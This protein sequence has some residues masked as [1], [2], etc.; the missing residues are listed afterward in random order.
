MLQPVRKLPAG[1]STSTALHN[2][3]LI[4]QGCTGLMMI[5]E[6]GE[7]A[8][9]KKMKKHLTAVLLGIAMCFELFGTH[10]MSVDVRA[11][12][13]QSNSGPV[14]LSDP[15]IA[16][17]S[18]M[19]SG[20]KVTWDCVWFG[21]YPQKKVIPSPEKYTDILGESYTIEDKNLYEALQSATGWDDHNDITLNGQKYRRIR[22]EDA[23]SIY[24][25]SD[26]YGYIW[27]DDNSWSDGWHYFKYEPIK[28]RIL[29]K[30]G[31]Q[32]LLL[33]DVVLD[34]QRFHAEEAE[35]TWETSTVRSWLN[36]YRAD[37]NQQ[38]TSYENK[39]F[40]HS[41]FDSREQAAIA[42]TSVQNESNIASGTDAGNH[43]RD[44]IFFL[45]E[46]ESYGDSAM[47]YGFASEAAVDDEARRC[48]S[49]AFAKAMGAHCEEELYSGN[50]LWWLRSPGENQMSAGN[51]T[52]GGTVYDTG[53]DVSWDLGV[54][55][56]L[57]LELSSDQWSYAG[58]VCSDG[59]VNE[60]SPSDPDFPPKP[61]NP[62]SNPVLVR[63]TYEEQAATRV[64]WDCIYFGSYPQTEVLS[65]ELR[66]NYTAFEF[67]REDDFIE[68]DRLYQKLQQAYGWD[69]RNDI[70]IDGKK[71]RRMKQEDALWYSGKDGDK[72]STLVG[73][74]GWYE[75][76]DSTSWH[77][78]RYDPIKWRVLECEGNQAF[79]VADRVLDVRQW[80]LWR[81]QYVNNSPWADCALRGWLNGYVS[82]REGETFNYQQEN[83]IDCAFTEEEQNLILSSDL[84]NPENDNIA[85]DKI[86]IL[87]KDE[88]ETEAYGFV[89]D[90]FQ[91]Q[92]C[93][94]ESSSYAKAMGV[95]FTNRGHANPVDVNGNSVWWLRSTTFDSSGLYGTFG[96]EK[97]D[98][99]TQKKRYGVRPALRMD[100]S[101]PSA[102]TRAG[103]VSFDKT[104]TD[105]AASEGGVPGLSSPRIEEDASLNAGR[106]V[107]WDCVYFGSYPQAEVVTSAMSKD[108]AALK[109]L[110]AGKEDLYISDSVYHTLESTPDSSWNDH[111]EITL[112]DGKKYRRM[113][114]EDA[115]ESIGF[116]SSGCYNWADD[117][118]HY[119]QYEPVKW[120]VLKTDG[121]KAYLV[122]DR[123][124][125]YQVYNSRHAPYYISK[126]RSWLNGYGA[127]KNDGSEDFRTDR[128]FIDSAFSEAEQDA[129]L[130]LANKSWKY[131]SYTLSS[132]TK[133]ERKS[134]GTTVVDKIN[135]LS[136]WDL[137][138]TDEAES[139]G[140][141]RDRSLKDE[142]RRCGGSLYAKA[143]GLNRMNE[144]YLYTANAGSPDSVL[145]TGCFS[146]EL[147]AGWNGVRPAIWLD[148]S[149]ADCYTSAGTV[150]TREKPQMSG[151]C[152]KNVKWNFHEETGELVISGTGP[153][154]DY[155]SITDLPWYELRKERMVTRITVE[156]GVTRI[157]KQAFRSMANILGPHWEDSLEE[158]EI[159]DSVKEIG[160]YAFFNCNVLKSAAIPDG[161]EK[162]GTGA[163]CYCEQMKKLT[164]GNRVKTVGS[165]AFA[166]SGI[167]ELILPESVASLGEDEL[168][169]ET[170]D[171]DT[172]FSSLM[173]KGGVC[174]SCPNL[175]RV[176]LPSGMTEIPEQMFANCTSLTEIQ[177]PDGVTSIGRFAFSQ[178]SAL[179]EIVIPKSVRSIGCYTFAGCSALKRVEFLGRAPVFEKEG[180]GCLA[181]KDVEADVYYP[182]DDSTW[183]GDVR[184]SYGGLLGWIPKSQEPVQKAEQDFKVNPAK[185]ELTAGEQAR[186]T[187]TGAHG[188]IS[189]TGNK[190]SVI[191]VRRDGMVTALS[192]GEAEITA[193]ASGDD[194]YLPAEKKIAVTV[195]R[196]A[197]SGNTGSTENTENT[198]NQGNMGKEPAKPPKELKKGSKAALPS[199]EVY[200]VTNTKGKTVEYVAPNKKTSNVVIP[201][202]VRLEGKTYTV[203]AV[204]GSAFSKNKK[205]KSITIG[206][207][208]T[209][210]GSKAF[211]QCKQLK[212]ITIKSKKLKTIGKNA[213]KGIHVK[214]KIKVPRGKLKTYRKLFKKKG[215]GKKVTI[216]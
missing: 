64:T 110:T 55:A 114:K 205:V 45:S 37:Q 162:V 179:E 61:E 29:K 123:A 70:T 13:V 139:Y 159:A 215:Q 118:W 175:E 91:S 68:S 200:K 182:E 210:I 137:A 39:G 167:T 36:G 11:Q 192:E 181:F 158:V 171:A 143:M 111:N 163:F 101:D 146:E 186:I 152:G 59:T 189:Y 77:Y 151:D 194:L 82:E 109:Y 89:S 156:D 47:R 49:S 172:V 198:G 69:E 115:G 206:K 185:L 153:M 57:N 121:R 213:F 4:M 174:Y 16:E 24:W 20:Q 6:K 60:Q 180:S 195:R 140:F 26:G 43:T 187:V 54:R 95:L 211:Y 128:N 204:A 216:S 197:V 41:A 66:R 196:K 21:G 73:N 165:A 201:A 125:D 190:D 99:D 78:F 44:K 93:F 124:L 9:N 38:N 42:D 48:I 62:L 138:G 28:W 135:L 212:K 85:T 76:N 51:V 120:R 23:Q 214:A 149:A 18:E 141:S 71:Y 92:C 30:D 170:I 113:K 209:K 176:K 102:Y 65:T 160:N 105:P 46:A 1:W 88:T 87:S 52:D 164:V 166:E 22:E 147:S 191:A 2:E 199:G 10:L 202:T 79:L 83:F 40:I 161:T 67:I 19:E 169:K 25:G 150:T 86:F 27:E 157:G 183:S 136:N 75:W 134:W 129:I 116:G 173:T 14:Q 122:S 58:T 178:C 207:N 31:N 188:T 154:D 81:E 8:M 148:L 17:S 145:Q 63:D 106:N 108:Y 126:V 144:W 15:V 97:I 96:N 184:Q 32:A 35:V 131:N 100:L 155:E 112:D 94:S 132:G 12:E 117:G 107:T 34:E 56:A 193:A 72:P 84:T 7:W 208:V 127:G 133:V 103:T 119:F 177:I 5:N 168:G 104:V 142:G 98:N 3:P 130:N 33:S 90:G 80:T 203:S 53:S 74:D 50:C